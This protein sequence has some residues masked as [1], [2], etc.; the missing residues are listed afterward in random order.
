MFDEPMPAPVARP[1]ALIVATAGEAE[2]QVTWLVIF[3]VLV[4]LYVPVAVNCPLVPLAIEPFAALMAM[5]FKSAAV[6]VTV[7]VP[8]TVPKVAVTV[9]VPRA[10]PVTRP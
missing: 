4:S 9:A 7:A 2:F 10:A 8:L 1:L 6:T 3:A 5:D